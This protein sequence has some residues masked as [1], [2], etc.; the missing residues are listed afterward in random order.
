MKKYV[1]GKGKESVF[2]LNGE[3]VKGLP[4]GLKVAAI[5]LFAVKFVAVMAAV[6]ICI[7]GIWVVLN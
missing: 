4:G 1:A 7:W 2:D 5:V 3:H 6:L